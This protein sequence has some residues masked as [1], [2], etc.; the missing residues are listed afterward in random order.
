MTDRQDIHKSCKSIETLV[1]VLNDYCEALG[2]VVII[3]KKLVKAL[4]ECAGVKSTAETAGNVP[5]CIWS[6]E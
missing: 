3:Q 5:W 1:N 2:A 6:M 4:R